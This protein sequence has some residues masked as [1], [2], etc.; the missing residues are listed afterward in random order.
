MIWKIAVGIVL[1]W[2]LIAVLLPGFFWGSLCTII[3]LFDRNDTK[4]EAL[5]NRPR[6][7]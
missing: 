6:G 7:L 1:A 3:S 2:F 4:R 5:K